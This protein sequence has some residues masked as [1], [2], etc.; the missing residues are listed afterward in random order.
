LEINTLQEREIFFKKNIGFNAQKR[1]ERKTIYID[2][3]LFAS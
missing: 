1:I 2:N 3:Q